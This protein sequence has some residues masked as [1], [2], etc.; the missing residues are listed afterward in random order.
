MPER[1]VG[2]LCEGID[3]ADAWRVRSECGRHEPT[4][5]ICM[6]AMMRTA[7]Q[8]LVWPLWVPWE[9][10]VVSHLRMFGTAARDS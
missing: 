6:A 8:K 5:H 10:A 7:A 4:M 1:D 2:G 3:F 9:G